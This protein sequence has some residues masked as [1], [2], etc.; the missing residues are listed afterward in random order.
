ML[1][2]MQSLYIE[3]ETFCEFIINASFK[4][5]H[6]PDHLSL[7]DLQVNKESFTSTESEIYRGKIILSTRV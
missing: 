7:G 3:K 5:N 1:A 2:K 4:M 6:I